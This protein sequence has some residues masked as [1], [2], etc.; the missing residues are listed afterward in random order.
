MITG[1]LNH[2]QYFSRVAPPWACVGSGVNYSDRH[3]NWTKILKASL[4]FRRFPFRVST[5]V[6]SCTEQRQNFQSLFHRCANIICLKSD[7]LS[8]NSEHLGSHHI[9]SFRHP[10]NL[11]HL[12][13]F[14]RRSVIRNGKTMMPTLPGMRWNAAPSCCWFKIQT[15]LLHT[16]ILVGC[17]WKGA[18]GASAM[19]CLDSQVLFLQKKLPFW[20]CLWPWRMLGNYDLIVPAFSLSPSLSLSVKYH[21]ISF[22]S[23]YTEIDLYLFVHLSTYQYI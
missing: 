15:I 16:A 7:T 10:Y 3:V 9:P 19:F 2:Q 18:K 11:S 23:T 14:M 12:S 8:N 22:F 5:L 1:F 6:N 20:S 4:C 13:W 17:E 21:W